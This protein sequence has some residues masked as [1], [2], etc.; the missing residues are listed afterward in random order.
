MITGYPR[1]NIKTVPTKYRQ[2]QRMDEVLDGIPVRRIRIPSLP[3]VS[4]VARG[5]QH[6]IVGLWLSFMI[7]LAQKA[8]VAM[9]FSPAL[10]L[11]WLLCLL[12]KVRRIPVVVSIQDLFR[13]EAVELGMLTNP[14]LIRLFEAIKHQVQRLAAG[15]TVHSPGN[16]KHVVQHGGERDRVHVVYN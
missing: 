12:G 16:K 1:Y 9:T 15:V 14:L 13:C 4:K 7:A 11:P 3:R 5:L 6:F 10:P 8:D 2:G